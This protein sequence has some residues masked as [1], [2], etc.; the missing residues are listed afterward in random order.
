MH[1]FRRKIKIFFG[2]VRPVFY[3]YVGRLRKRVISVGDVCSPV[4][5]IYST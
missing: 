4:P 3:S 5:I 1:G 2:F